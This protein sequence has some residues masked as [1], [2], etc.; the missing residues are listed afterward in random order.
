MAQHGR[1]RVGTCQRMPSLATLLITRLDPPD[2]SERFDHVFECRRYVDC[3]LKKF[4]LNAVI[5]NGGKLE[6]T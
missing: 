3:L 1:D 4:Y 2:C 5:H 6:V